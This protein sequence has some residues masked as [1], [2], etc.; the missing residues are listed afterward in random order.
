MKKH[1]DK[2]REGLGKKEKAFC[3]NILMALFL[4]FAQDALYF[5]FALGPANYV[6]SSRDEKYSC[7]GNVKFE[8]PIRHLLKDV[9]Q[10]AGNTSLEIRRKSKMESRMRRSSG[11]SWYFKSFTSSAYPSAH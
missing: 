9:E 6:A 2:L 8:V 1:H 5:H 4:L 3:F 11:C 7:F 10:A